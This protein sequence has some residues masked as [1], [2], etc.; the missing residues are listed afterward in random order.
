MPAQVIKF[1][2]LNTTCGRSRIGGHSKVITKAK[3]K[4]DAKVGEHRVGEAESR[5]DK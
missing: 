5:V 3:V 1:Q 4:V 2:V